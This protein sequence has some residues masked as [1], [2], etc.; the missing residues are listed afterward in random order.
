[1]D[2]N[3]MVAKWKI[4]GVQ[5]ILQALQTTQLEDAVN[6]DVCLVLSGCFGDSLE[7]LDG[8]S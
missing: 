5:R 2:D 8:I 3:L 6:E 7:L 1:M 4:A